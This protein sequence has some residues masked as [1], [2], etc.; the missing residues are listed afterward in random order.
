MPSSSNSGNKRGTGWV[1]TQFVLMGATV[2]SALIP[3]HWPATARVALLVVGLFIGVIGLAFALWAARF[4]GA[5]FTPFPRPVP[6]GLVTSGPFA[7]V[8]HPV[9]LGLLGLFVGISLA[10]GP[11]ALLLTLLLGILWAGKSRLEE[12]LLTEAYSEYPAYCR[13]VTKRLLPYLY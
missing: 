7:V 3:I 8:R 5:A 1:V 11:P 2:F 6:A 4:L 13:A 12:R 10:A 9:Y